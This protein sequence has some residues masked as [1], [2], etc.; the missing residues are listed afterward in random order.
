MHHSQVSIATIPSKYFTM[1]FIVIISFFL[2][3]MLNHESLPSFPHNFHYCQSAVIYK[4]FCCYQ[5]TSSQRKV[6][7]ML[8][9]CPHEQHAYYA[10]NK[11]ES[12]FK[13]FWFHLECIATDWMWKATEMNEKKWMISTSLLIRSRNN[14]HYFCLFFNRFIGKAIA[15]ISFL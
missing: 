1:Q 10:L 11:T 5:F 15:N 6:D 3:Q 13:W 8:F 7:R 14:Q 4:S 12:C 9:V 2:H